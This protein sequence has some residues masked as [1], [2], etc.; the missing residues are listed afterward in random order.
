MIVQDSS[1]KAW[2]GGWWMG[3]FGSPTPKRH[4]GWSNSE[5]FIGRLVASGGYLSASD[6]RKLAEFQLVHRGVTAYGREFYTGVRKALK[7]SQSLVC[8][9]VCSA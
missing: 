6:K 8:N 7:R 3:R 2:R 1:R 4:L 5:H 9:I